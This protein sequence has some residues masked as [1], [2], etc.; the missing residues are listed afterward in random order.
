MAR[1]SY[2]DQRDVLG[3]VDVPTLLLHGDRDVRSPVAV[4][5]ALSAAVP[6]V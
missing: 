2:T 1:A 5:E 3:E 4:G 6:G